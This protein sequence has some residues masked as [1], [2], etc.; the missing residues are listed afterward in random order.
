MFKKSFKRTLAILTTM[1]IAFVAVTP[2]NASAAWAKDSKGNYYYKDDS[3]KFL[4]GFQTIG[5]NTYYFGK[6]GKMYT[7]KWVTTTS[8]NKYYF[9]KDGTM[10]TGKIKLNGKVYEFDSNGKLIVPSKLWKPLEGLEWGMSKEEVI[11]ALDLEEDD[12][13]SEENTLTTYYFLSETIYTFDESGLIGFTHIILNNSFKTYEEL[14]VSD[15][16]EFFGNEEDDTFGNISFYYK[17]DELM[18][19]I[20]YNPEFSSGNT[21]L[22]V[23]AYMIAYIG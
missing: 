11:K 20:S 23:T 1:L 3:G 6:D 12:Y 22:K 17:G 15:G 13:E 10:T 7:S 18:A 8:G 16:F 9:K 14:L 19:A 2:I 21:S 5:D 4:T